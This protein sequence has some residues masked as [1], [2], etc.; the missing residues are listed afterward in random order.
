[1]SRPGRAP[2]S[3]QVEGS[4]RDVSAERF[5][6]GALGIEDRLQGR[7]RNDQHRRVG[8]RVARG[9]AQSRG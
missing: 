2:L 8:G 6:A 5:L 3:F 4:A 7:F 9:G 1:M